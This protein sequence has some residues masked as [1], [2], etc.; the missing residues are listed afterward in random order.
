MPLLAQVSFG[1]KGGIDVVD[2]QYNDEVLKSSN[3]AGFFAGPILRIE[4]PVVGLGIDVGTF[5]HQRTLKV[6]E[7]SIEQKSLLLSSHARL[8][9]DI[10]NIVGV[11][12]CAGPQFSFNVGGSTFYWEDLE[13]Y[14]KHFTLQETT[15]SA[16]LG[17]GVTLGS[18][19]EGAIYYN[20]PVGKTADL[21]WDTVVDHLQDDI[22]HRAKSRTDSWRI[23]FTYF[24]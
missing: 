17:V 5:Y 14:R 23:T 15:L 22:M 7:K 8:G 9:V 1:V 19:L 18:N 21:T 3:R 12:L 11:Y 10:G 6:E 20:I 24:F 4:T 13:G 16:D 2:M